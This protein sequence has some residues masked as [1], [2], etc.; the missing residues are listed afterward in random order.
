MCKTFIEN[1]QLNEG[2]VSPFVKKIIFW[3]K[4]VKQQTR[5]HVKSHSKLHFL[6]YMWCPFNDM[7]IM[8]NC[9]L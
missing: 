5:N 3:G 8:E 6:I 4:N 1:F 7:L 2:F 9:A